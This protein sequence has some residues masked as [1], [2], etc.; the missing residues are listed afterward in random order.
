MRL[1][2]VSVS[3]SPLQSGRAA[4]SANAPKRDL[5]KTTS[6][7]V[8]LLGDLIEESASGRLRYERQQRRNRVFTLS[9]ESVEETPVDVGANL[10][11]QNQNAGRPT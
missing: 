1:S 10:A 2:G 7:L 4:S 5:G 8:Y 11:A 9:W 6:P 3:Y